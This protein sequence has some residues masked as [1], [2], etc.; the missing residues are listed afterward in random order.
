MQCI[1]D[2]DIPNDYGKM[3]KQT[4]EWKIWHQ[5]HTL[6]K[7]V[8]P[9]WIFEIL[10]FKQEDNESPVSLPWDCIIHKNMWKTNYLEDLLFI[11][12]AQMQSCNSSM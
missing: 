2:A 8:Q 9:K 11:T 1:K 12:V 5:Y 4:D 6:P 3:D 7:Q 10:I